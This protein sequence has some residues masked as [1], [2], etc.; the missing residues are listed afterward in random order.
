M[1]YLQ[2]SDE[3]QRA[4]AEALSKLAE[5]TQKRP[6]SRRSGTQRARK[7]RNAS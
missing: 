4:I 2:G 3:R 6:S 1:I 7:R 5:G